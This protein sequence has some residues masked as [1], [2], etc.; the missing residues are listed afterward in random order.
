MMEKHARSHP[1]F[2]NQMQVEGNRGISRPEENV[3][4]PETANV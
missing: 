2:K 3:V 4:L 1:A